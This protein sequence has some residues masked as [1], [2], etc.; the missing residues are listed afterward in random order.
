MKNKKAFGLDFNPGPSAPRADGT[1]EAEPNLVG[2]FYNLDGLITHIMVQGTAVDEPTDDAESDEAP[3]PPKPKKLKQP[4]ASKPASAPKVSRAKPLATAPPEDSVQSED[5][6]RISKPSRVKM[7]L[8]HT[9]QE[10]TVAAILRNDAIDLSSDEDLADDTLEQLIKSKEEQKSSMICLSLTWQSYT[11][12]LMS[13]LT[14]PTS[15]SKI[16]NFQ[17]ASVSP[18]MAPLLQS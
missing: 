11:T 2:P 14:R 17:L 8:Q 6:S 9:S 13:G 5:L 15:A 10:L 18:S 1:H 16:C 12:S 3:A 4:K 7:P